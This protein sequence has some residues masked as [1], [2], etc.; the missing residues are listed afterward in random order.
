[1]GRYLVRAG[2]VLR[3]RY[4]LAGGCVPDSSFLGQLQAVVVLSNC[5][6]KSIS[7]R[8]PTDPFGLHFLH[9]SIKKQPSQI[10]RVS[11]FAGFG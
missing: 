6:G 2:S 1:M 8:P 7:G 4:K 3:V 9:P 10:P 11:F 5:G